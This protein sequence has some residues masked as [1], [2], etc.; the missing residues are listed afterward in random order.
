MVDYSRFE[1]MCYDS[2]EEEGLKKPSPVAT[3]DRLVALHKEDP[4]KLDQLERE[5]KEMRLQAERAKAAA[6]TEG[7]SSSAAAAATPTASVLRGRLKTGEG[8]LRDELGSL[9]KHKEELREQERR[10]EQLAACGDERSLLE[11]FAEQGMTPEDMQRAMSGDAEA[12]LADVVDRKPADAHAQR[13]EGV[14]QLAETLQR[15]VKG[16]EVDDKPAVGRVEHRGPPEPPKDDAPTAG[17]PAPPKP[18]RKVIVQPAVAQRQPTASDPA[19]IV[20]ISLPELASAA[21]AKLDIA[22]STIR[23]SAPLPRAGETDR[24]YMVN[25]PLKRRVDA[26]RAVAR[27]K[28][29]RHDLVITLPTSA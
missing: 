25:V 11:F 17:P 2:D 13:A 8:T 4:S 29:K 19:L 14:V 9:E 22:E 24:E 6:A 18:P 7:A 20:T 12:A 3:R 16:E 15:V 23:L 1:K 26:K 5:L 21:E 27:W 10:L 28:A